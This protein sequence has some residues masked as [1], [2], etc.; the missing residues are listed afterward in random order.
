MLTTKY[1]RQQS[2]VIM[3]VK[4]M[5]LIDVFRKYGDQ[6]LSDS[7]NIAAVMEGKLKEKL[8]S[9]GIAGLCLSQA[10]RVP[11]ETACKYAHNHQYQN[12]S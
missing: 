12:Q 2:P 5:L 3:P 1:S 7:T 10:S 6:Q 4:D 11:I 9:L 8:E